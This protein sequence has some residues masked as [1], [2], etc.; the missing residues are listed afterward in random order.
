MVTIGCPNCRKPVKLHPPNNTH[1]KISLQYIPNGTQ[2]PS[3]CPHC[4][5]PFMV[6]WY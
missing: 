6:Y 3:Q 1:V 2:T 5:L 4:K